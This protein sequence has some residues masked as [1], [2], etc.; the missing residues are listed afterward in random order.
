[1]DRV[2]GFKTVCRREAARKP[3]GIYSRRVLNPSALATGRI[4]S[5]MTLKYITSV[6]VTVKELTSFSDVFFIRL[7][8]DSD[9]PKLLHYRERGLILSIVLDCKLE[10]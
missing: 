4:K 1:M 6:V 10:F 3:I 2:L 5:A 7:S 9:R 8:D